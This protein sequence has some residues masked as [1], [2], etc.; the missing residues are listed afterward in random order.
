MLLVYE[1]I[2]FS[3]VQVPQRSTSWC[4]QIAAKGA[5]WR[6][7][8]LRRHTDRRPQ[9]DGR[10]FGVLAFIHIEHYWYDLALLE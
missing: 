9:H 6:D 5:A 1:S 2:T 3:H 10:A 4:P 8:S 7:T